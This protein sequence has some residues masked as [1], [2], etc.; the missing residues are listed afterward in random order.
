MKHIRENMI[1]H[2]IQSYGVVLCTLLSN[3]HWF[4]NFGH[5]CVAVNSS[6]EVDKFLFKAKA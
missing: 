3:L 5:G 1:V 2:P 4:P 6:V